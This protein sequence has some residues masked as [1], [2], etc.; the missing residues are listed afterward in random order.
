MTATRAFT[1]RRCR[2]TLA[3]L[4]VPWAA[5]LAALFA[6]ALLTS[7]A[8]GQ[9]DTL[10][11]RVIAADSTPI[12]SAR[13]STA[14]ADGRVFAARA[15]SAGRYRIVVPAHHASYLVTAAAFGY[16]GLSATVPV[17]PGTF[18][19]VRS[20]RLNP[21]RLV[22][23][24]LSVR[25]SSARIST[26]ALSPGERNV[27]GMALSLAAFGIDPGGLL[28]A[29]AL[30]DG[31]LLVGN[32][33]L[34]VGGQP[35]SQNHASVDGAGFG[36]SS[37]PSEGVRGVALLSSTYDPARGQFSGGE[38]AAG[39]LSGTN[40]WGG[41]FSARLDDPRLRYGAVGGDAWGRRDRD[42]RLGAG[43]GGALVRDRLFVY[44]AADLSRQSGPPA[45]LD[46]AD[47]AGLGRLG[48]AADSAE[49]FV[50]IARG[51]GIAAT[52][53]APARSDYASALTR[54]DYAIS[55]RHSLTLRLDGRG[56]RLG[57]LAASPL[58]LA[59]ADVEQRTWD[60]GVFGQLSSGSSRWSN[61]ARAYASRGGSRTEHGGG[62]PAAVVRV[63][64]S[65]ADATDG[66]AELGF[67]G[68]PF[69]LPTGTRGAWE[70]SDELVFE[71]GGSHRVKLA[72]L[73]QEERASRGVPGSEGTFVFNGLEDLRLGRPA[74]F[75]RG[76]GA[77]PPDA[78]RRY[79][80]VSGSDTWRV[81]ERFRVLGG[82]RIEGSPRMARPTLAAGLEPLIGRSRGG[83]PGDLLVSPRL[84]FSGSIP[85]R[86]RIEFRGGA[87]LFRGSTALTALA[88]AWG[89]TGTGEFGRQ[90]VCVGPAAPSPD[91][92][93][94]ASDPAAVPST[95][96]GGEPRFADLASPATV[97]APSFAEP[98]VWRGS[99]GGGGALGRRSW[100][101]LDVL[102]ARGS[103][104]ASAVDRNR[105]SAAAFTLPGENGRPVFVAPDAI[106]PL[107]GGLVAAG[108]RR[109]ADFGVVR[110]IGADAH[111]SVA[112]LSGGVGG[113]VSRHTLTFLSFTISRV[114]DQAG[115]VSSPG[116]P[117]ATTG[118]DAARLEWAPSDWDRRVSIQGTVTHRL[119]AR[120][121]LGMVGRL[122][123]GLPFTPRVGGD[124]NGDGLL[125]DRAFVFRPDG[126]GDTAVA[127]GMARLLD[128]APGSIRG[129]LRRQLG[130]VAGRNSCRGGWSPSLDGHVEIIARGDIDSRR[131][132]VTLTASNLT[133]GLDHLLHGAN[134]LRG[135]GQHPFPDATLLQVRGFDPAARA[136]RYEVNP[137]FGRRPAGLDGR[138]P[139]ALVVTARIAVGAD[140]RY[141]PLEAMAERM[142]LG[143]DGATARIR[144]QLAREVR[145]VPG[146]L[147]ALDASEPGTLGLTAEQAATLQRAS[148]AL[149]PRLAAALDAL[150]AALT[151]PGPSTAA[152][153]AAVD[154]QATRLQAL[155]EQGVA[156]A[157]QILTTRQWETL[158]AW[159]LKAPR[160]DALQRPTQESTIRFDT[161]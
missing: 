153:R 37:L 154:D 100:Y 7:T 103:R 114:D 34:S 8:H 4:R 40:R 61:E 146:A 150:A 84:G 50:S 149:R 49:R 156:S 18:H 26:G 130:T 67:G 120:V 52:N 94:F 20:F 144:A 113:I 99:L 142:G 55:R 46:L 92:P 88:A 134:G 96:A 60:A 63:S 62:V 108:S 28:D 71:P 3:Y 14:A 10:S 12:A 53:P 36:A 64:S 31:A 48:V 125:N 58:R 151:Q 42:V 68:L 105:V 152:K 73:V 17:A 33:L 115:G 6:C 72:A 59:G 148:D 85:G 102:L 65:L 91:W 143:S 161:P 90:L 19:A 47:P 32:G 51:L 133:A 24:T 141:Q 140:P 104:L 122:A 160:T 5:T 27:E 107:S 25:T 123:S 135:W 147:L 93:A 13:V 83:V 81:S 158:P 106:D 127:N 157:R 76:L 95:C 80:A 112:Q 128:Q 86:G 110:E 1:A 101:H 131:L 139:F 11:G 38:V 45:F 35:P 21:R 16:S 109:S 30:E 159:V 66:W 44:A 9:A 136:F 132:L 70:L 69:A 78:V 129:C 29:A 2:E 74:S 121:H 43:G 77:T 56:S 119:A 54:L 79:G 124:V 87:G 126:G 138:S 155:V 22:L 118:G 39:T 98:R 15:D 89:E 41:A 97:F 145:N 75:T 116:G 57:G 137:G 82:V 111:S 117:A 23:D